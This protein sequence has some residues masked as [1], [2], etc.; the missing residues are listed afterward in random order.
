MAGRPKGSTKTRKKEKVIGFR[1]DDSLLC[2]IEEAMAREGV[3]DMSA[4]VREAVELYC[5]Q[6]CKSEV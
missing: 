1:A 3:T 6:I 5:E 4:F 2:K